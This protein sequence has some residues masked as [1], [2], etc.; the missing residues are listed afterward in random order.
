MSL[1]ANVLGNPLSARGKLTT[2][3]VTE[4][5]GTDERSRTVHSVHFANVTANPATVNLEVYDGTN[6]YQLTG[7]HIVNTQDP[8][9]FTVE[10]VLLPTESIRVTAGTANALHWHLTYSQPG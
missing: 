8:Y 5:L 3:T 4:L 7:T 6:S 1:R 10:Q 9:T 2:A